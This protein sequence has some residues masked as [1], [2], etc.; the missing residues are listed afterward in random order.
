MKGKL[1]KHDS[2]K[3][4]ERKG[5]KESA[6]ANLQQAGINGSAGSAAGYKVTLIF[7]G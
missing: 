4:K 6:S 7:Y 3:R 5:K 1:A 2:G